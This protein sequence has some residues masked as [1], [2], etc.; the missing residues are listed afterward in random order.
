MMLRKLITL[1]IMKWIRDHVPEM[2]G[3]AFYASN[4]SP[5]MEG[6]AGY[7]PFDGVPT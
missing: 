1:F 2:P 5:E 7:Y 4:A 3:I 6:Q